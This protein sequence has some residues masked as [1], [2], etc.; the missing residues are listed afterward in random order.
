MSNLKSILQADDNENDLELALA[1][2]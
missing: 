2:I 1:S